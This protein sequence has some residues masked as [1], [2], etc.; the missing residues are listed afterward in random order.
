MQLILVEDYMHRFINKRF[1]KLV[2]F[3]LKNMPCCVDCT[4]KMLPNKLSNLVLSQLMNRI[5][6]QELSDGQLNYLNNKWLELVVTDL[7]K[8]W[9]ISVDAEQFVVQE[10]AQAN[11]MFSG[12]LNDFSMLAAGEADPDKL[13]FNRQLHITGETEL[14]LRIKSSIENLEPESLPVAVNFINQ[15]HSRLLKKYGVSQ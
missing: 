6:S 1:E 3:G 12:K 7:S 9:F 5:F 2:I 13:F 11:V 14:G 8:S 15:Q 4:L 10:H